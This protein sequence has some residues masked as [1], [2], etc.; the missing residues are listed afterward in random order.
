MPYRALRKTLGPSPLDTAAQKR[1][2]D[3]LRIVEDA[4]THREVR[5][6]FQPVVQA[7]ESLLDLAGSVSGLRL[8][9]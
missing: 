6:A 8:L 1:D 4:V 9:A 2:Q 3:I 5:L 7:G